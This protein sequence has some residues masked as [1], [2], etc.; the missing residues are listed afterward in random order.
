[1]D[2]SGLEFVAKSF[3]KSSAFIEE[4]ALFSRKVNRSTSKP[5]NQQISESQPIN[6]STLTQ[7]GF[8]SRERVYRYPD[9]RISGFSPALALGVKESTQAM[10]SLLTGIYHEILDQVKDALCQR[11]QT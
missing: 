8:Y 5:V 6:Q 11:S 10:L 2:Q 7:I 3:S 4:S 9:S 1:M